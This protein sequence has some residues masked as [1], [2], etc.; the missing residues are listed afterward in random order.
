MVYPLS[1]HTHKR[2]SQS[3]L[4]TGLEQTLVTQSSVNT[5]IQMY[6]D[7]TNIL[8]TD[9]VNVRTYVKETAAGAWVKWGDVP[10]PEPTK[11]IIDEPLMYFRELPVA[12]SVKV[13]I[14]QTAGVMRTVSYTIYTERRP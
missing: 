4:M 8:V 7:L 10:Y 5:V 13:T 9:L 6:I 14:Q 1:S 3:L 11:P 2:P 12:Y